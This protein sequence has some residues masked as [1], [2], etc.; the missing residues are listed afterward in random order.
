MMVNEITEAISIPSTNLAGTSPI[1]LATNHT[2]STAP[3]N[4]VAIISYAQ[5]DLQQGHEVPK[6][7]LTEMNAITPHKM[8]IITSIA[9]NPPSVNV[10]LIDVN[11]NKA[12][13]IANNVSFIWPERQ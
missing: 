9:N 10:S 4:T 2:I 12:K 3:M 5:V 6:I 11:N 8:I 7:I 13:I 1:E